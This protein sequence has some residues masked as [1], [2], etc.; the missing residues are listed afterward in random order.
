MTTPSPWPEDARH[1]PTAPVPAPWQHDA[2]VPPTQVVP[3]TGLD[4]R[5]GTP[6]PAPPA[7]WSAAPP[8]GYAAPPGHPQAG[9]APVPHPAPYH[10]P[11]FAPQG[12]APQGYAPLVPPQQAYAAAHPGYAVVDPRAPFGRDPLTGEPLSDR[13]K[14]AAGLLQLFL[15]QFGVGRFYLGHTAIGLT[16]LLL[17]LGGL[18][19]SWLG[20]GIVAIGAVGLW[21]LI[22]AIMMFTGSVRDARGLRLRS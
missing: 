19:T 10:Q 8:S 5:Y 3:A 15:G 20:I 13:S 6:P 14:V 22:D 2:P 12:Y 11:G 4:P 21:A 18:A 16:Q 7:G 1:Q 17:F 9:Y